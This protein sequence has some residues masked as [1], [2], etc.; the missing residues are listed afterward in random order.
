MVRHHEPGPADLFHVVVL[1]VDPRVRI[2]KSSYAMSQRRYDGV[3]EPDLIDSGKQ[4][5][6][7]NSK[8]ASGEFFT[9]FR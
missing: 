2:D 9:I 4:G 7:G 1:S 5:R 6:A 8:S 3:T